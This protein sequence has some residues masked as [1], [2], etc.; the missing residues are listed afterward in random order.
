MAISS[1]QARINALRR[2]SKEP[3][4]TQATEA[5]RLA[6]RLRFEALVD[7]DGT[8]TPSERAKRAESARKAFYY[9]MSLKGVRARQAKRAP[10]TSQ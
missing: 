7:P 2:W 10:Q 4:R 1:T 3:D 6:N 9:E 5:A 8:L